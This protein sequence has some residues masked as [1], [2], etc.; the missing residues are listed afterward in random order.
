MLDSTP[1]QIDFLSSLLY[2]RVRYLGNIEPVMKFLLLFFPACTFTDW[3]ASSSRVLART[4]EAFAVNHLIVAS[5][6]E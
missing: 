2:N 4:V 5:E 3:V 1:F 6:E